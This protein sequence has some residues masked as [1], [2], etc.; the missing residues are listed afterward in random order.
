MW[1]LRVLPLYDILLIWEVSYNK[2]MYVNYEGLWNSIKLFG[3]GANNTN[4]FPE[5][6]R[7]SSNPLK[8]NMSMRV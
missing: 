8:Y 6:D 5:K 3:G 1:K 7:N 2:N 4:K